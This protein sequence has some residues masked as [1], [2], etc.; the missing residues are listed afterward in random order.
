VARLAESVDVDPERLR[1]WSLF[2][3]V[4]SG[5]RNLA[6]G[7]RTDGEMLLEFASWL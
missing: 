1:A 3:A 4:E 6:S 7:R 5:V 2:R